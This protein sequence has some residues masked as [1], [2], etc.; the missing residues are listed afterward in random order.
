MTDHRSTHRA[1]RRSTD[2]L[3]HTTSPLA[4]AV[5]LVAALQCVLMVAVL[6]GMNGLTDRQRHLTKELHQLK[7]ITVDSARRP[8]PEGGKPR[9]DKL[10]LSQR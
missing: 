1:G 8:T 5:G 7:Q 9:K 3:G 10:R 4:V 6:G 2:V